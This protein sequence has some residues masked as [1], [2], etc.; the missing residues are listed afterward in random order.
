MS[1]ENAGGSTTT[2]PEMIRTDRLVLR[3]YRP[4][5]HRDLL[6]FYGR[7]DVCRYLLNDPWDLAEAREAVR[8]RSSRRALAA[9]AVALVVEYNG[10]VVGS[11]S[12]WL[13]EES[14][15]T[16][17]SQHTAEL[18]WAFSPEFGGR[19]FATEAVTALIDLVFA[20]PRLRRVVA[21]MDSRN[22]S[23]AR[24]AQRIG[25][26]REAHFRQ[27]AWIKNEWTD[28]VVFATLRS[29]WPSVA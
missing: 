3:T 17:E 28:T 12:A 7:S 10:R 11:V 27:N 19:G 15:C 16:A 2:A 24:L 25:M 22:E 23:S 18:G 4:G 6:T 13:V 5:D 14:V 21:Q 8:T 9:G 26:Q 20:T 1:V 29:E